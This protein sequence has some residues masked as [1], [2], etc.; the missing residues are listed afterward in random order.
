VDIQDLFDVEDELPPKKEIARAAVATEEA[1]TLV[2]GNIA[3][4][5]REDFL[6][7]LEHGKTDPPR[8][9]GLHCSSLWKTCPRIPLLEK[10]YAEFLKIE[11]N[12]PGQQLTYD[13]GH[14]LHHWVQNAWMG[15]FGRL[16]GNWKCLSCQKI[17]HEGPMPQVCPQ[18]DVIW[19]NDEDG[20]Q[21]IVYDEL[22]VV[23][24]QLK[25]CGHCD[26][27][28]LT[29]A[30]NKVVF[31]FKTISKSQ[32]GGLKQPKHEHI[33]QVH[34][35]MAAL[36]LKDA[37]VFY[38]D[39]GSQADWRKL[40]DGWSCKNPHIKVFHVKWDDGIWGSMVKRIEEYHRADKRARDL[41]VVEIEHINE[42]ARVCTHKKC[43]MANDCGVR[44]LCFAI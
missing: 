25:Y 15:P 23:N 32:Y 27:I 1:P 22:F 11:K 34:A 28:F 31:E 38:L 3:A 40:P 43:D 33:I 2:D 39:K 6:H 9:P 20:S 13:V 16:W 17:T 12:S 36:G 4:E 10:K 42:F 41:P 24:E 26:G 14:A 7:W 8:A 30:G 5:L 37:I 21:N 19:R 18:C 35:Y 44:D 29:R